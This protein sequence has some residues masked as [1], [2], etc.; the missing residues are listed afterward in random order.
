MA[1]REVWAGLVKGGA[2][3]LAYCLGEAREHVYD[4]TVKSIGTKWIIIELG[5]S[6]ARFDI[7]T[8]VGEY[9]QRVGLFRTSP[10]RR[11][12]VHSQATLDVARERILLMRRWYNAHGQLDRIPL[13]L[14]REMV[15]AAEARLESGA[16]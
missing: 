16:P 2:A 4:V 9:G 10:V 7:E 1:K 8:G 14:L 15:Q 13:E 12:C 5:G 3:K 6:T 11:C